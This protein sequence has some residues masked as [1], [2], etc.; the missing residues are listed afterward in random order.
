MIGRRRQGGVLVVIPAEPGEVL[1]Q[2]TRLP[3]AVRRQIGGRR[4][5]RGLVSGLRLGR[6]CMKAV[7]SAGG[8]SRASQGRSTTPSG[9]GADA[10][11]WLQAAS[12]PKIALAAKTAAQ[13]LFIAVPLDLWTGRRSGRVSDDL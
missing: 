8:G 1:P 5:G 3:G 10:W 7:T 9:G 13:V 11:S 2:A 6:A 12:A 4:L